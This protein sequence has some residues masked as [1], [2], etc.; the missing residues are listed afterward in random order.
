[1]PP[2]PIIESSPSH[3]DYSDT[4]RNLIRQREHRARRGHAT[5]DTEEDDDN[6]DKEL[7]QQV[8][9]EPGLPNATDATSSNNKGKEKAPLKHGRLSAEDKEE[10]R[11]FST[12]VL[13]MAQDV[14]D[15]LRISRK[16]VLISAGFGIRESRKENIANLHAQW[17]AST[18]TKPRGS[19]Y[20][21][22]SSS[23]F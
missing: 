3:S 13:D 21:Y 1:L 19:K 4:R 9:S 20:L 14:A 12:Q 16:N 6:E 23:S 17:Y 15:R 10:I 22:V 8:D 18:H 7:A 2:E 11:T 5:T